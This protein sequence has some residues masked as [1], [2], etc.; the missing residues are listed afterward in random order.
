[1]TRTRKLI[2]EILNNAKAQNIQSAFDH[3]TLHPHAEFLC[4]YG[5]GMVGKRIDD[6]L[7][8]NGVKVDFF[9]ISDDFE[10]NRQQINGKPVLSLSELSDKKENVQIIIANGDAYK[11]WCSLAKQGFLYISY[12][13]E[14]HLN[15]LSDLLNINIESLEF[16]LNKLCSLIGDE[17]SCFTVLTWLNEFLKIDVN[18]S[19]IYKI[20]K[21]D[22]YLQY[23]IFNF[24]KGENITDIGA[25]TGD[26]VEF[27]VNKLPDYGKIF[28][29]EMSAA[30]YSKL[31]ENTKFYRDI[32]SFNIGLS[33]ECCEAFYFEDESSSQL[34][35]DNNMHGL[36]KKVNIMTLDKLLCNEKVDYIKMD[37]EGAEPN[38]LLGSE[39]TIL[40]YK[41]K[42][43]ISVYHNPFHIFEIPFYLNKL[44]PEYKIYF[45]HHSQLLYELVCYVTM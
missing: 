35:N 44:V 37:I 2:Q 12:I 10:N 23:D 13:T 16:D 40:K 22:Q 3:V 25:F 8:M 18:F 11:C 4:L 45:R 30:N 34:R 14:Y 28:A 7:S 32:Y 20:Y 36:Q 33:D 43:A 21:P 41:P 15:Y 6:A 42:C 26:T 39:K 17:Y 9:V 19:N 24:L 29:I 31:L 5:A 27:F 38:A 1:M